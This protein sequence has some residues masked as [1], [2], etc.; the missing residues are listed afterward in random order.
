MT[1]QDI[2]SVLHIDGMTC[3]SCVCL[4]ASTLKGK[5]GVH[6]VDVSLEKKQAIIVYSS[7]AGLNASTLAAAVSEIGFVAEPKDPST[8]FPN[9]NI[10]VEPTVNISYV[11]LEPPVTGEEVDYVKHSLN[12]LSGVLCADNQAHRL[13]VAIY[14]LPHVATV[15]TL[16]TCLR[17]LDFNVECQNSEH[18]VILRSTKK[19]DSF[20]SFTRTM[21]PAQTVSSSLASGEATDVHTIQQPSCL[22]N[23]LLV[24]SRNSTVSK[25]EVLQRIRSIP[26]I[27]S[28]TPTI[29][30]AS[31]SGL[32]IVQLRPQSSDPNI[33]LDVVY[34]E[35][36]RR[37]SDS[38]TSNEFLT[39]RLK[40]IPTKDITVTAGVTVEISISVYGMHCNS[41]TRTID[42]HFS[43][44]LKE[45]PLRYGIRFTTCSVSLENS[46]VKFTSS[47]TFTHTDEASVM[48]WTYVT[49]ILS[50][51][52]ITRL[53]EE[54]HELGF[55]T[56]PDVTSDQAE[57]PQSGIQVNLADDPKALSDPLETTPEDIVLRDANFVSIPLNGEDQICK[58]DSRLEKSGQLFSPDLTNHASS[59]PDLARCY[60]RITGMTCSSCVHLIEQSL[61]KLP[62]VHNVL[63]ALLAMKADITYNRSLITAEQLAS[64]VCELGF[65]AEVLEKAV[66]VNED[67]NRMTLYL[68]V[69]S[70]SGQADA[71]ALESHLQRQLGIRGILI[72]HASKSC[73]ITFDSS[74]VGPRDI[75]KQIE[76]FGHRTTLQTP[77]RKPFAT[78]AVSNRWRNSFFLSLVFAAPT[79]LIMTVFMVLWPHNAPEGC[80]SHFLDHDLVKNHS[81]DYIPRSHRHMDGPPMI[82]PGLSLENFL[83]FVLAT[84]IQTLGGRYFYVQAYK[85]ISH[86]M[87]NMDVL[88]VMA[89]TIAYLYS[90]IIL[91]IAIAFQWPTSPRTVFETSP[92]LFVFVSLGRWL[93]HIAKGKTSEALTKLLALKPTEASI[94]VSK[95][96]SHNEASQ[97]ITENIYTNATE[98]RIPVELVHRGDI[99]K[100]CP[101]EKVPVDSR[102]LVGNSACDESL[103]TGESMPVDKQPGSELIGGAINLT[104]VLWAEATHVG[105]D[106]ALAQIVRLVEEAQTSKAP[107][108]QLAD[109]IAGYFVPFVC[110]VSLATFLIWIVLGMLQ[111]HTIL[112]YEP[113]CTIT[114]LAVDHAFRMAISVLT[115]ACPCALGLATPTAVMVGTGT[116]ALAGI[117][118]KGGQPLE[119]MRKLTTV[120]FDKTGTITQGRPQV[121]HV[122]MFVPGTTRSTTAIQ[123][124]TVPSE[125]VFPKLSECISP[126]RFLYILASAE[127]TV[128]HPIAHAIVAMVRV[129][130]QCVS[131]EN[132]SL[133]PLE[134]PTRLIPLDDSGVTSSPPKLDL[135]HG[136]TNNHQPGVGDAI[137]RD[138]I[139][140][141]AMVANAISVAGMGLQCQIYVAPFD[142][143]PG[144][145]L[146]RPL[147]LASLQTPLIQ[148]SSDKLA[149]EAVIN[150]AI[151]V[152]LDYVASIWPHSSNHARDGVRSSVSSPL[153]QFSPKDQNEAVQPKT[154]PSLDHCSD[155]AGHT[156]GFSWSDVKKGGSHTVHVG[157]RDWIKRNNISFPILLSSVTSEHGRPVASDSEP[158]PTVESLIEADEARGQ[159]V[160]LIAIDGQL[161]GLVSI[162]DPVK[163]EAALAVAAL[164]H[165]G[166]RVGLLTGDNSRT[167]SAIARQVGIRDVY[168]DVLPA[169]K[170]AEVR[171]LQYSTRRVPKTYRICPCLSS[172]RRRNLDVDVVR[173]H[174]SDPMLADKSFD[175]D[176]DSGETS[177]HGSYLRVES[178]RNKRR[179]FP[180]LRA[181]Y[182]FLV[183]RPSESTDPIWKRNN[184]LRRRRQQR[185]E[186]RVRRHGQQKWK[187]EYVAMVGDG[188]NDS[189]ALAQADVGIAIGRGADVAVEAADVVLV[190]DSLIDVIGA[191]DLSR[192]TVRRIRCNFVAA[193]LYNMIG[194]PVAAGCLL[195]FGIE[196]AP[197]M[198]SAAMAASSVSVIGLSLLLRRWT[199]PTEAS[200]VCPE[201]VDLLTSAGLKQQDVRVRKGG[202]LLTKTAHEKNNSHTANSHPNLGRLIT[203]SR[204][205]LD[206]GNCSSDSELEDEENEIFSS[207]LIEPKRIGSRILIGDNS[208]ALKLK[209]DVRNAR[210]AHRT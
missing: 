33:Y 171:R 3:H 7:K 145:G 120:L 79:M 135:K 169:H 193:T 28:L 162:E 46:Q 87:A 130:R 75:I 129:F 180:V 196:L 179:I 94:I 6:H 122:V 104:N 192:A 140:E 168:A 141:F 170:A 101:G 25:D 56:V 13:R 121:T 78:H 39:A 202:D 115:I 67:M 36:D 209:H 206:A 137:P 72:S 77:D 53:H 163:P 69:E 24:Q 55:R 125:T 44:R 96:Q 204:T 16:V 41:C 93:E 189:P 71:H 23:L 154:P 91:L 27:A 164:R 195:P 45:N 5:Q 85:S 207:S 49:Q 160:V 146:P 81:K 173:E 59:S 65:G 76:S 90:V 136:R 108:Q 2:L 157:N 4:I 54:I 184:N 149:Q 197:W 187:R 109:R 174:R 155:E 113:G 61:M 152:R 26:P 118:I 151:H 210:G 111:P 124:E 89:T 165:R 134:P 99:I 110:C 18:C 114:L 116:G 182:S 139:S 205:L 143:P 29:L 82:V 133:S 200:L 62:G 142:C 88:I 17:E 40:L 30:S 156:T 86:G 58:N 80:P 22:G 95:T 51:T 10:S 112:G 73:S 31:P 123:T 208:A 32:H 83:M 103:I 14:H 177:L 34:S 20:P 159:T 47:L 117:L 178:A 138:S 63:V 119:N 1:D 84:P 50:Q 161:V 150:S 131:E 172:T 144:P 97:H 191:I 158:L 70:L 38:L 198:A 148:N 176:H 35:M 15:Q 102:V 64:Q 147:P 106:S 98:K 167:A 12:E 68:R 21:H 128:K 43:E 201:Y 8:L 42:S 199:K 186:R 107:I 52:D 203:D 132:S 92:M 37:I 57:I 181:L 105:N 175:S 19:R 183:K 190:R 126:S 74:L 66:G 48:M 100:I 188:V 60:L 11:Q 153:L 194:I 166:V 9:A 185:L 127:S